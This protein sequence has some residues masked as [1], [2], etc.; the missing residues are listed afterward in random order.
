MP[1]VTSREMI[2][3]LE[4]KGFVSRQG[5]RH[6]VLYNG[7]RRTQVPRHRSKE[8]GKGLTKAILEQAGID[9]EEFKQEF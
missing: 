1:V 9:I 6:V 7:D 8:L 2:N 4:R 3:Y 5:Q